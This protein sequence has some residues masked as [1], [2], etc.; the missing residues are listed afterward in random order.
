MTRA[1]AMSYARQLAYLNNAD[2]I[3]MHVRRDIGFNLPRPP[4]EAIIAERN[5]K[6]IATHK[7]RHVR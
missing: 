2:K 6:M 7:L 4:V 3:I 5:R 1:A